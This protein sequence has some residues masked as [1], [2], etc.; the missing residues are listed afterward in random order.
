[1]CG[2]MDE[3][4]CGVHAMILSWVCLGLSS[5]VQAADDGLFSTIDTKVGLESHA[6]GNGR[7]VALVV[8]N[9]AYLG[10]KRLLNPANDAELIAGTLAKLS[11]KV[12]ILQN[13]TRLSLLD[14]LENFE[15]QAEGA[16]AAVFY[17]S[18]HGMQD[19]LKRNYLLPVDVRIQGET[20]VRAHGLEADFVVA[21]LDRASPRVGL[22]LLDACRDNPFPN[23]NK[24][25]AR[26]LARMEVHSS[27]D[28]E[29]LIHFAT[30][31][32]EVA[33][34]GTG[35]NSPYAQALAR[36][37]PM[38]GRLSIRALLDNVGDDV[39]RMTGG[40]QRPAQF[41]EMRSDRYLVA[42]EAG[43][44]GAAPPA[45][46]GQDELRW[47]LLMQSTIRNEFESFVRQF[48]KSQYTVLAQTRLVQLDEQTRLQ[49]EQADHQAWL[50]SD[51]SGSEPA[52]LEYL[53][54]FPVGSFVA[55]ANQRLQALREK[56]LADERSRRA[57]DL[58][59]ADGAAWQ[60]AEGTDTEDAYRSY[61]SSYPA[62]QFM[63]SAH[64]R[65]RTLADQARVRKQQDALAAQMSNVL[66][67]GQRRNVD[68][69]K[70]SGARVDGSRKK[71]SQGTVEDFSN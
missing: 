52:Y 29:I 10:E 2:H 8:G 11:F 17:F 32:G 54:S 31:D 15:K 57:A 16:D 39:R 14:G 47:K 40:D 6:V 55:H 4:R 66:I 59:R 58:A 42:R 24:G 64:V 13:A 62:G 27:G 69:A 5:N 67:D 38:A 43:G 34:D 23:R 28:T 51:L 71:T 9:S 44:G 65:I 21:A 35:T 63:S 22:I 68:L 25:S 49:A 46:I 60:R 50:R 56:V 20:S 36:Q 3:L 19:A 45:A 37:L 70:P 12:T 53:R 26:G 41:G 33:D 18:G 30:R 1:M 61:L 48:P 7:K